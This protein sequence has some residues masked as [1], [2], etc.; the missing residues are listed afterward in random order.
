M[1]MCGVRSDQKSES[2]RETSD[3]EKVRSRIEDS[4]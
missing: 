1:G 3:I 4:L 2:Y